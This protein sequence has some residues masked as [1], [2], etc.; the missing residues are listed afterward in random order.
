MKNTTDPTQDEILEVLLNKY[1]PV[2]LYNLGLA[3]L[4]RAQ[5]DMAD[6]ILDLDN[7]I[8]KKFDED[9]KK[10]SGELVGIS[11]DGE[12]LENHCPVCNAEPLQ[13]CSTPDQD[14]EGL[15]IELARK[16]HKARLLKQELN[17]D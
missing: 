3:M 5:R 13:L 16:V 1:G 15:G 8:W 14:Q 6:S 11:E 9:Q 2:E 4:E 10:T 12:G 17:D 7:A